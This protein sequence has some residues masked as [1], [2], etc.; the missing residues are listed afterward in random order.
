MSFH[1]FDPTFT[2]IVTSIVLSHFKIY[3]MKKFFQI[4]AVAAFMTTS[5]FAQI[6]I[7]ANQIQLI[8]NAGV[9]SL[10][11]LPDAQIAPG[12]T[13]AQTWDFSMLNEDGRDSIAFFEVSQS[14]HANLFPSANLVAT[15]ND[16]NYI[17]LEKTNDF[18]RTHG[19]FGS[20]NY[21]GFLVTTA[22]YFDS[23]QTLISFPMELGNT[24]SEEVVGRIVVAGSVLQQSV[25]SVKLIRRSV[26]QVTV[27][28]HG[29][30]TTPTGTFDALRS[31]EIE[32]VSDSI[33]ALSSGIWFPAIANPVPDTVV[34]YNWWTNQNG[35]GFPVVQLQAATDGTID[36]AV[37]LNSFVS[38]VKEGN[39]QLAFNVS[40]N[41]ASDFVN[42]A[43][44]ERFSGKI[45]VYDLNGT[46]RYEAPT[47]QPTERIDIQA[48]AAGTYI[49]VLK[50]P[51]GR[52]A[53]FERFAVVR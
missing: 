38:S 33:Y 40:P 30:L 9:Q 3:L 31:T 8:G 48:L 4:L 26:R 7:Q 41:P 28:A 23:P 32:I 25:D 42:L 6:T 5:A 34:Y 53:G 14:P 52:I 37:W 16:T 18:L 1:A 15:L 21:Q 12:G 2:G 19:S 29:S 20:L 44:P 43:L 22:F 24:T 45:A 51:Q 27:D 17:Y 35:L 50:D 47:V 39:Q 36:Q 13:G 46:L 10:D 49:L 11:L